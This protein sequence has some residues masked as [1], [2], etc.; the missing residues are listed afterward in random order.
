MLAWDARGWEA[1]YTS[2]KQAAARARLRIDELEG[3]LAETEERERRR[4]VGMLQAERKAE[5]LRAQREGMVVGMAASVISD[6]LAASD[7]GA[8]SGSR[9]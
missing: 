2:E 3:K 7:R 8:T 9:V 5:L 6:I 1:G 4:A